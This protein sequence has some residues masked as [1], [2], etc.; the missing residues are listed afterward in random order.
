MAKKN[1]NVKELNLEFEL[2]SERVKKL[3]QKDKNQVSE[4]NVKIAGFEVILNSYDE[5]IKHLNR[6]LEDGNSKRNQIDD[7]RSLQNFRCKICDKNNKSKAELKKHVQE[8]HS[9]VYQCKNCKSS[10]VKSI[11][12]ERH[13]KTSHLDTTQHECSECGKTFVVEWRLKKHQQIHEENANIRFCHYF[14]NKKECPYESMGCMFIHRKSMECKYGRS[15]FAKLCQFQHNDDDDEK[16]HCGICEF[17]AGNGEELVNHKKN[18]HEFQ[19][20]YEMDD[21]ERYEVNEFIC[22]NICWQGYHKCF[23][24]EEENDFLGIDVKKVKEDFRNCVDEET[25][26]CEICKFV[27]CE[28]ENVNKHFLQTHKN[29]HKLACWLCEKK[30]KSIFDMRKH[31]GTYH[32]TSQSE[33]ETVSLVS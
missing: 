14:N 7:N 21:G 2:L 26:K 30:F 17:K 28:M 15:C 22:Y 8:K 11:D 18:D 29:E 23:E 6:L 20:F 24:K 4:E 25:F 13:V 33:S 27:S 5:K 9:K 3:E 10:F 32:Y 1:K 19:K 31:V 16:Y 12:L